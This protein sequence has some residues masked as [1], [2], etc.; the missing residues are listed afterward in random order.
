MGFSRKQRIMGDN[1]KRRRRGI[2]VVLILVVAAASVAGIAWIKLPAGEA[3]AAAPS[4]AAARVDTA[5]KRGRERGT[6]HGATRA[7]YGGSCRHVFRISR[8]VDP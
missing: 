6:H 4:A 2:I 1:R 5:A 8:R 3:P 7:A